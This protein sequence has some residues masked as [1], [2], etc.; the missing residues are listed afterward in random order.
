MKRAATFIAAFLMVAAVSF[1]AGFVEGMN[2]GED[3]AYADMSR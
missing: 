1:Y 2:R 3:Q